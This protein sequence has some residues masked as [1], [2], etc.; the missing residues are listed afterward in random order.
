MDA[1]DSTTGQQDMTP[2]VSFRRLLDRPLFGN[3]HQPLELMGDDLSLV[4]L[5]EALTPHLREQP[6]A[7]M[8][9]AIAACAGALLLAQR[10]GYRV[11][12][13]RA[14]NTYDTLCRYRP[15]NPFWSHYFVTGAMDALADA[16][17][18][19]HEK[20]YH[21]LH[22]AGR[23][24]V[25]WPTP[26]LLALLDGLIDPNA[27]QTPSGAVETMVLRDG[28]K[29]DIDYSDTPATVRM[30]EQLEIINT[31]LSAL[32]IYHN[33]QQMPVPHLR[34]VFNGDF[35]RGGRLYCQG[36]SFQNVPADERRSLWMELN[37]QPTSLVEVDYSNLHIL[38]A[39]AAVGKTAPQ[40]DQ[41]AINGFARG[42]VKAATNIM[43]NAATPQAAIKAITKQ[44]VTDPEL[45]S[46]SGQIDLDRYS[47]RKLAERVSGAIQNRHQRIN[48]FFSSD[49]GAQFQRV[50]SNIAVQVMLKFIQ[51]TGI[52]PLPLHDSFLV[53][54]PH[55]WTLIRIMRQ[56]ARR[57]GLIIPLKVSLPNSPRTV[58]LFSTHL[59]IPLSSPLEGTGSELHQFSGRNCFHETGSTASEP[60]GTH[61]V[62][63]HILA[64]R[65]P[66][67]MPREGP[68][69]L[70][71]SSM[72][73]ADPDQRPNTARR[74]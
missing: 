7:R 32:K 1:K 21:V 33:D 71:P 9:L 20:G 10:R 29:R 17:L 64:G 35:T 61:L 62:T 44:L 53:P 50:D 19:G 41:Y 42:L 13:S 57:Q 74:M 40:G 56:E 60:L 59:P 30:R 70:W 68:K 14:K 28:N 58:R 31:G 63:S 36:A 65:D 51:R 52:A 27:P 12:Y 3:D 5:T 18:I 26:A 55:M 72:H 15:N 2:A 45:R 49:S 23:Q 73:G 69:S 38:M 54:Q 4:P 22:G 46:A 8:S 39:Y 66:P 24:S 67:P 34:R 16:G 6:T 47:C 48:E 37:G 25:A 43:I 11:H